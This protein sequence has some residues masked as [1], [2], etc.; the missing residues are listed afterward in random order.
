M[1]TGG[2][3]VGR[4]QP[5]C[6]LEATRPRCRLKASSLEPSMLVTG[7][8]GR[9]L[10]LRLGTWGWVRCRGGWSDRLRQDED[11]D[12]ISTTNATIW[13]NSG[14]FLQ[15]IVRAFRKPG[16]SEKHTHTHTHT[17]TP[18]LHSKVEPGK[19]QV[20]KVSVC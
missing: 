7:I 18:L 10:R 12:T 16:S 9:R 13:A 15:T 5:R 8:L 17:H 2:Y 11:W 20:G 6:S 4:Q 3:W 1:Q 19:M 14:S